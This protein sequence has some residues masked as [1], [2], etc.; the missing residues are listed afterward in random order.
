MKK[1]WN[2]SPMWL[3]FLGACPAMGASVGVL[4]AIAMG[5]A[6]IL[7]LVLMSA[8]APLVK[9][10][11]PHEGTLPVFILLSAGIV[12]VIQLL[13]NAFLPSVFQMLGVY[14]AAAAVNL[15]VLHAAE[16]STVAD[17]LKTGLGFLLAV[18]L[19]ALIREV[20]GSA[21]IAGF[22]IPFLENYCIPTLTQ[23][24]GGFF[25]YAMVAALANA[26]FP[27]KKSSVSGMTG[28]ALGLAEKEG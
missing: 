24:S 17:S 7:T 28:K 20:F 4:P 27:G 15:L 5:V 19:T 3:L 22:S 26:I 8:L 11:V 21:S 16:D 18:L 1:E 13:M 23:G 6:V 2:L 14:L 12:S 25:V 9:K 10:L